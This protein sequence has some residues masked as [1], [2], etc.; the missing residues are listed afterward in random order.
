MI[1]H[2]DFLQRLQLKKNYDSKEQTHPIDFN[3]QMYLKV[4]EN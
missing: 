1:K 4:V 3:E 2:I